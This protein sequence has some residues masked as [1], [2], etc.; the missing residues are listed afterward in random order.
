M[1][2]EQLSELI[3][4]YYDRLDSSDKKLL[5]LYAN[6]LKDIKKQLIEHSSKM[7][8]DATLND[9]FKGDRLANLEKQI[10]IKINELFLNISD[11]VEKIAIENTINFDKDFT[12]LLGE[13]YSGS[14]AFSKLNESVIKQ[15]VKE[16]WLGITFYDRNDHKAI[17]ML[18]DY[19]NIVKV[20][21]VQGKSIA[22]IINDIE[23]KAGKYYKE[24]ETMVRSEVLHS[25]N[26][27]VLEQYKGIGVS[28]VEH[29][30]AED[31]RV[32][33]ICSKLH[34]KKYLINKAPLLPSST[35]ARCRCTY[36]VTEGSIEKALKDLK[37]DK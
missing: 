36:L 3:N 4:K 15:I 30:T 25:L 35:H 11:E 14:D 28:S 18:Y 23:I 8:A 26:S 13:M 5:K 10:E 29:F 22:N 12:M 37:G 9:W 33:K 21:L 7:S 27:S 19:M 34:G 1:N 32:C 17:T 16:N 31:E 2:G 6:T 24:T 20:G